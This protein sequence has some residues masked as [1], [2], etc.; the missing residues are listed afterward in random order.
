MP[1]NITQ[2]EDEVRNRVILRVDGELLLEDATLLKKIAIELGE[3]GSKSVL[4]DL[5]E[6]NLI[7]SESAPI[8]R[9]LEKDHKISIE[10]LEFLLQKAIDQTEN[11]T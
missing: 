5:S 10:G 9:N 4:L 2:I 6:L 11:R 8:L 3:D 7:D 1:T